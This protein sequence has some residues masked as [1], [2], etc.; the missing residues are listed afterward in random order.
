[1]LKCLNFVADIL[2]MYIKIL[3][4]SDDTEDMYDFREKRATYSPGECKKIY[5]PPL[6][7]TPGSL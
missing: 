7:K 3:L 6:A 4:N 1:M 2:S 5:L